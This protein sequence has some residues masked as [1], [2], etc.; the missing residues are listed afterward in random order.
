MSKDLLPPFALDV[1]RIGRNL[2]RRVEARDNG[3]WEWTGYCRPAGYGQM[4]A[5]SRRAGTIDT[6][7]AS[8]I[9]HRGPIPDG[10][11]VCHHCDNRKCVNPDHLFLGTHLENMADMRAKGRARGARGLH[12]ANARLT[13]AQVRA[14]RQR[15]LKAES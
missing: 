11:F 12:N 2:M 14:I 1:E 13:D 6:H 4:G 3:C 8:W 5:G 7:R 15:D 10:L 9:V